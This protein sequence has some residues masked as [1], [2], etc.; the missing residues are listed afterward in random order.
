M[1]RPVE[2]RETEGKLYPGLATFEGP[3]VAEKYKVHQNATFSK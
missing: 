3:A 2:R 1:H